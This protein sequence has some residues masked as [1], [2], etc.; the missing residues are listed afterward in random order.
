MLRK[1]LSRRGS[2]RSFRRGLGHTKVNSIN[3]RRMRGG[4]RL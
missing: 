3:P 1:R 4:I 2:K